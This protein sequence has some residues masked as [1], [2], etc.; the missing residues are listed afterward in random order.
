MRLLTLIVV[1]MFSITPAN[2]QREII[3]RLKD[4]LSIVTNETDKT[5]TLDSLAMLYLFFSDKSDSAFFYANSFIHYTFSLPEKKYLILAYARMSFYYINISQYKA[6]LDM[7]LKGISLSDEYNIPDYLSALYYN[8]SWVY[9][10]LGDLA[11]GLS[12]AFTGRSFLKQDKDRFYDQALHLNGIIGDIYLQKG[13]NDSAFHYF[14]LVSSIADTSKELAAK[15]ISNWYWGMYYLTKEDYSKADTFLSEGIASCRKNGD[16]LLSFF[17]IFSAQS[18]LNQNKIQEAIADSRS[19]YTLSLH[20]NDPAGESQGASLLNVC[21]EKTKNQDSAYHY[22]KI[23]DSLRR[24]ISRSGNAN[25]IQQIRL[26]QQLGQKEREANSILQDQKS[27]NR[28]MAYVFITALGF[29][30]LIVGIQWRNNKQKKKANTLLQ[31]QK[32]KI[33]STLSELKSTQAQLIQSEK[34]SSLGELTAGIAHEIQNPLNFVNNFASINAELIDEML[35]ELVIG[36]SQVAID[37]ARDIKENEEKIMHHGKRAESIVK[38]MLQHSRTST[39]IKEPTDINA[40]ADEYMRLSYHGLRAKDK[41]FNADFK[42]DL[43]PNL[44]LLNVI[45]QDIGRVLL[46]ILN[47]AFQACHD[48][49]LLGLNRGDQDVNLVGLSVSQNV[50]KPLVSLRTKYLGDKIEISISDNGPGIPDSIRDKIFQPF[51]TTKPTGQG[52]GLGLSLAYDIVKAHGGELK[53]GTTEGEARPDDPV[54]RGSV[55]IIQLP[56]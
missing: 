54:G 21:Y 56:I 20:L 43:D 9:F 40:L 19:A 18:K 31:Q 38:G 1:V 52:T 32:S 3:A 39:G 6:A 15:D 17:L 27:K 46:N 53:V 16:F 7:S 36:N 12:N 5:V 45:P 49:N 37:L 47:N 22:L 51:F 8:C 33:E 55:F 23:A 26:D 48:K 14:S 34:M 4:K 24:V 29:F 44:P 13:K 11:S 28:I 35:Q 30:G 41:N 42:A 2:A 10:N 50:Y 25:E